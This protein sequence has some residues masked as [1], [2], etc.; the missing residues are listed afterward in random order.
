MKLTE[1][2]HGTYVRSRPIVMVGLYVW[3]TVL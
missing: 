3:D 2:L 1:I